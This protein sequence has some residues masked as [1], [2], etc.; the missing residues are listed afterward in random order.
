[1]FYSPH[2]EEYTDSNSLTY[3]KTSCK[4]NATSQRWVNELA[5]FNFSIH[6]KPGAQNHVADTLSTFLIHKDSCISEYCELFDAGE[7]KSILDAAFN[8][9]NNDES[10][11][12]TVNVLSTSYNDIQAEIL[13]KGGDAAVCSFTRDNIRKAQDQEEWIKRCE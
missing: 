11:I 8:R 5:S 10:W 12:P 13:Y 9:Q 6:Y 7:I 1:M 3:I 4:I 2:F